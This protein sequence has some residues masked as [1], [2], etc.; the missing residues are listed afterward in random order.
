[1]KENNLIQRA[2]AILPSKSQLEFSELEF[3]AMIHFGMNTY[4]NSEEGTGRE[5]EKYFSPPEL[6]AQQWVSAVKSAGMKG[7]VLTCKHSDGFCLWPSLVTEHSVKNSPWLD[8]NGDVV[9]LVSD[10]CQKQGI[11]FGIYISPYDKHEK[12]FGS[13]EY[14]EF[15]SKQLS[16]LLTGYGDIFCVWLPK[17]NKTSFHYNWQL[18]YETIRKLQPEAVICDCGPDVRWVGNF[19]GVSRSEEWNVV[20]YDLLNNAPA[21]RL[22]LPDLGSL[23]KLKK[24]KDLVWYPSL[25]YVSLRPS[26][27][28]HKEE[29]T[30]LKMLSKIL[31]IYFRSVGNNG[32]MA[33]SVPVSHTG[34]IDKKDLDSLLTLGAQLK[35]E[36]KEDFA[37]KGEFSATCQKDEMHSPSMIK[38]ENGYW[39]SGNIDK[40]QSLFLEM[41][42]VNF[43]NKIVIGENTPSGQQ[44]EKFNIF[45]FFDGKWRKIY[46]GNTVGRKKICNLE[47]MNAKQIRLDILKTRGFATIKTFEVY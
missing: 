37:K 45:Y 4:T 3:I 19:G 10:E 44:I 32:T 9:K 18:Y 23:K 11:K 47:P 8:G 43:I 36:F 29:E 21:Q 24:A 39:H 14:D 17:D 34:K 6:D 20:P 31:E 22:A 42:E 27:F 16:E 30:N 5:P 38:K 35:I 28:Y 12:S 25:T 26:W 33:L 15:F 7:L 41:Q 40:K 46:S 13:S 1:M 2:N